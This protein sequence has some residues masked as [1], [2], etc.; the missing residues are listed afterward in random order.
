L[1]AAGRG[2]ARPAQG[3]GCAAPDRRRGIFF[4]PGVCSAWVVALYHGF[5]CALVVGRTDLWARPC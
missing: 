2:R 3:K 1:A 5:P 4:H